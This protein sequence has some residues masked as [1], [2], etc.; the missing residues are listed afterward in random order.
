MHPR[1]TFVDNLDAHVAAIRLGDVR[2]DRI[3]QHRQRDRDDDHGCRHDPEYA[4]PAR[5]PLKL[6]IRHS[7]SL[8][9]S[10]PTRS[11]R[12][13]ARRTASA[14]PTT[15]AATNSAERPY[16]EASVIYGNVN[17]S[18]W[19]CAINQRD[20]KPPRMEPAGNATSSSAP[21]SASRT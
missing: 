2:V 3:G 13:T 6:F 15:A 7:Y 18:V 19:N 16:A 10:T 14:A 17:S 4:H 21:I 8:D 11:R 12:S 1:A 20:N 9:L 5:A